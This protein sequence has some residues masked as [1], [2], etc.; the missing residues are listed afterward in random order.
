MKATLLP[1]TIASI[2]IFSC[3][4]SKKSG[5]GGDK[6]SGGSGNGDNASS[7]VVT[8]T[9]AL[10]SS[11]TVL[12]VPLSSKGTLSSSAVTGIKSA[13][14]DADGSFSVEAS[15]GSEYVFVAKDSSSTGLSQVAGFLAIGNG[16]SSLSLAGGEDDLI[17]FPLADL[18]IENDSFDFGNISGDTGGVRSEK[19]L[20]SITEQFDLESDVLGELAKT[21][22]VVRGVKNVIANTSADGTKSWGIEPF[23]FWYGAAS[24]FKGIWGAPSKFSYNGY[25]F[26]MSG[27]GQSDLAT[28]KNICAPISSGDHKT[29]K[30]VPPETI[31]R[32]DSTFDSSTP[33]KSLSNELVTNTE[34]DGSG[35]ETCGAGEFYASNE[36][37]SGNLNFNFGGDGYNGVSPA[38]EWKLYLDDKQVAGFDVAAASPVR[39]DGTPKIYVPSINVSVSGNYIS[40][41]EAK[42]YLY[43]VGTASYSEVIDVQ[44]FKR[45]TEGSLNFRC[46]DFQVSPRKE[47][48]SKMIN[49]TGNIFEYTFTEQWLY[50]D[51]SESGG[52]SEKYC[53]ALFV[54][55]EIAG[56]SIKFRVN[57]S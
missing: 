45:V 33:E 35:R 51:Q 17:R 56:M 25:G 54:D 53:S 46:Y 57:P 28:F 44:T 36:D 55:F 32:G 21:D 23:H 9:L 3:S 52:G 7:L 19:T 13:S 29:L 43:D 20:A 15:K 18:K 47:Y 38:G 41:V 48:G 34:T 50:T 22:D 30:L 37:S 24:D 16:T 8:G 10:G 14:L 26:Y 27:N 42:F 31:S 12:A 40:K 5:G 6:D 1:L 11:D 2:L 49:T 4:E 39:A